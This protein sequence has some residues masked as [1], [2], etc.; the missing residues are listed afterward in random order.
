M[1]R[2]RRKKELSGIFLDIF[3]KKIIEAMTKMEIEFYPD[4]SRNFN[5]YFKNKKNR[6]TIRNLCVKILEAISNRMGDKNKNKEK[7][8]LLIVNDYIY[9]V[10]KRS[11]EENWPWR[12]NINNISP[13]PKNLIY[14]D[15]FIEIYEKENEVDYFE[16]FVPEKVEVFPGEFGDKELLDDFFE[17]KFPDKRKLTELRNLHYE[18]NRER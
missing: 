12:V 4:K 18:V 8:I 13:T 7:S 5:Y 17:N 6:D 9:C 10:Y 11:K 1:K 16:Q 15:D 3:A 14:F 2:I